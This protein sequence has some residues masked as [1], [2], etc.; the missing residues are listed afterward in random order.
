MFSVTDFK[1]MTPLLRVWSLVGFGGPGPYLQPQLEPYLSPQHWVC[2]AYASTIPGEKR[3]CLAT[4]VT[5]QPAQSAWQIW[6]KH[7]FTKR[8]GLLP[9][10]G[11]YKTE[12]QNTTN[13]GHNDCIEEKPNIY[14][15]KSGFWIGPERRASR[16]GI[17]KGRIKV[18]LR[19][20]MG[21]PPNSFLAGPAS[22]GR[23][24]SQEQLIPANL[25]GK[26]R[27]KLCGLW[28][29]YFFQDTGPGSLNLVTSETEA[30]EVTS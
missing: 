29:I 5:S 8:R 16:T 19:E 30:E 13:T 20:S 4:F 25:G 11:E 14:A 1:I 24:T 10:D 18:S 17:C 2:K 6:T 9:R 12:T 7:S 26:W 28:E 23:N 22:P 21:K 27:R 3:V 15:N